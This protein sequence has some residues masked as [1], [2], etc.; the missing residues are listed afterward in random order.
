MRGWA[1]GWVPSTSHNEQRARARA[2][3]CKR[4]CTRASPHPPTH[5]HS[6]PAHR[7]LGHK[8]TGEGGGNLLKL[9]PQLLRVQM[10]RVELHD[11][12]VDPPPPKGHR[13]GAR[14]AVLRHRHGCRWVVLWVGES[15]KGRKGVRKDCACA[16]HAVIR[17][18]HGCGWVVSRAK[19]HG[20]AVQPPPPKGHRGSARCALPRHSHPHPHA[21]NPAPHP[22]HPRSG[23]PR[24][25]GCA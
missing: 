14:H 16:C 24:P 20:D 3:T 7:Q 12:G 10:L 5:P 18:R 4:T 11:D 2:R 1:G 17:H 21:H 25:A 23:A 8:A 6:L 9:E 19:L 15:Q 22:I 13:V